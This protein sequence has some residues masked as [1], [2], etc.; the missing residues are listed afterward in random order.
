MNILDKNE[1]SVNGNVYLYKYEKNV[2]SAEFDEDAF[3]FFNEVIKWG[4]TNKL[5]RLFFK[6]CSPYSGKSREY[7]IENRFRVL[8]ITMSH[9]KTMGHLTLQQDS[10][11]ISFDLEAFLFV[12]YKPVKNPGTVRV[13]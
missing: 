5:I 9:L 12:L 4:S 1:Y 6:L 11:Q 3:C 8:I 10:Q 13:A 7:E 2:S